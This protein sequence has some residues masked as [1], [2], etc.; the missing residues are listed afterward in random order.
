ML[1]KSE[2]KEVDVLR[3]FSDMLYEWRLRMPDKAFRWIFLGA[4]L[5]GTRINGLSPEVVGIY[6]GSLREWLAKVMPEAE[7]HLWSEYDRE[8]E[9]CRTKIARRFQRYVDDGL[10]Y[11]ATQTARAMGGGDPKAYLVERLAEAMFSEKRFKP[12]KK[13]CN[14]QLI[15]TFT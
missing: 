5:Y 15:Y 4:D 8:A 3:C 6:F 12:V 13:F 9:E 7:F 14:K 1:I 10:L 11:R 2:D